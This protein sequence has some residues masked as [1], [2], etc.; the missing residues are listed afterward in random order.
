MRKISLAFLFLIGIIPAF[1]QSVTNGSL[2][3][4]DPTFNRPD[5][6][7][8]PTTL[9]I[10]GTSVHYS[11]I[12]LNITIAGLVTI[13]GES[14]WDNFLVLYSSAGFNP[15][16]PLTNAL[17]ANDD[18]VGPNAGFTY[19]FTAPGTYYLVICSYKN[20]VTGAFTVNTSASVPLPVK[21]LSFTAV[22]G[23]ANTNLVKWATAEESDLV[24]FQVQLSVNNAGFRDLVDGS[25]AARNTLNNNNYNFTD[26]SPAPANNYY[27]LKIIERSGRISYS[28]VAL[29]KNTRAG[30]AGL[31][32]YPNPTTSYLQ[33]EMKAMRNKKA[34]IAIV[35]AA[36]EIVQNG[37]YLF[38]EQ[39]LITIDTRKLPA[40][41]YF[42]KTV[43]D[44]E[45]NA[46]S[47]I[48]N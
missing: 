3:A 25:V 41:K 26:K 35:N 24:S 23:T 38:S 22:K 1:S 9:S 11:V 36:G 27:R 17:Y 12:T 19:N 8:P 42:L 33:L 15:A 7:A 13:N 14:V 45:V 37:Q 18:L 47:F 28:P 31:H 48:R 4:T 39:S 2:G 10:T 44:N 46:L 34:T 32:I 6:G 20:N 40:G 30:L 43:V 16:D 5:E 21:L 29:V